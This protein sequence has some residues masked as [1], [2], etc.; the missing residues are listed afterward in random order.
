MYGETFL[1]SISAFL[2]KNSPSARC[3]SAA[4]VVYR[5]DDVF[6]SIIQNIICAS[7]LLIIKILNILYINLCVFIKYIFSSGRS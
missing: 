3:P 6:L 7:L 1:H 4:N 2:V 5:D